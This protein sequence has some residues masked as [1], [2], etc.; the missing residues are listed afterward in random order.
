MFRE[1]LSILDFILFIIL[2]V[3]CVI[4]VADIWAFIY[5]HNTV[6]DLLLLGF[7]A[8]ALLGFIMMTCDFLITVHLQSQ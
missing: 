4:E 6:W 2:W 5:G 1:R 8:V 7:W 3:L